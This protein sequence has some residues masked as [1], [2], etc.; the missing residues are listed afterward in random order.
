[1]KSLRRSLLL[2]TSSVLLPSLCFPSRSTL[3]WKA[4]I[5]AFMPASAAPNSSQ[6]ATHLSMFRLLCL[7]WFRTSSQSYFSWWSSCLMDS[8]PSSLVVSWGGIQLH[9]PMG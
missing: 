2:P 7:A 5:Q 9:L 8:L 1:M 3:S 4:A 6:A